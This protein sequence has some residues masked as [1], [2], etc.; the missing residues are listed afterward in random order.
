MRDVLTWFAL[1]GAA[2]SFV[3]YLA[4]RYARQIAGVADALAKVRRSHL[5]VFLA[6]ALV[7]T[8][9]AQ[10]T[11]TNSPPRG[12]SS[13]RV[14]EPGPSVSPED[15]ARGYLLESVTTNAAYSYAMPAN[16]TRYAKWWLR[17]AYED[18]FR[19]DLGDFRFPLGT[20]MCDYLWVYTWGM[21]G[22]RLRDASNRV[23]AT[24]VPMSAVPG[25]SQFWD[26]PT[27]NGTHLLTWQD[28]FLGRDTNTPV[29]AQLELCPTGDYIARSNE[30]ERVYRRVNPDDWDDDGD[31]NDTDTNPY[32]NDGD[33]FGPHQEL[34]QGANEDAYCW[35]DIVVS[36]ANALVTFTGDAPS[37]LP[38]PRFIARAGETNRVIIL[39]GKTYAVTCDMPIAVVDKSDPE[40]EVYQHAAREIY[41]HWPVEIWSEDYGSY[42]EMFVSPDFLDGSFSWSTNGCCEISGS[43]AFYSFLCGG[44]CGCEGCSIDGRYLY[45]G[46]SLTMFSGVCGCEPRG[47]DDDELAGVGV[48]FSRKVLFYE[49]EYYDEALGIT[50]PAW[51]GETV[52]LKCSVSGGQHGGVFCLSLVNMDKLERSGGDML[53][54]GNVSVPANETRSWRAVYTFAEHSDSEGDVQA[55]A[56]FTENLSGEEMSADDTM[57]V[58]MLTASAVEQWPTNMV[59]RVFGVGETASIYKTPNIAATA[60]SARGSCSNAI[61]CIE[62][63][64]PHIEC[65]D[66]VVITAKGCSHDMGFGI[67]A[68]HGYNVIDVNSNIFASAGVSGGFE[69]IFE[70]RLLPQVVSF[71]KLELIEWP[72]V[73]TDPVGYYGQPSKA[74]L[75]DHGLHGAGKWNGVGDENTVGDIARMEINDS[76]WLGGGSFTWPIPNAWR[77]KDHGGEG[78][79]FCNTDQRFELDADGT[80]RLKKFYRAGE[81]TTNGVYRTWETN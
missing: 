73:S 43:G 20:Y 1:V 26:A 62:Y 13:P 74:G 38:D 7:A 18:V 21:A 12:A 23:V 14:I 17:G 45:E 81:R 4:L 28:F 80:T 48:S 24:G 10:K 53:P 22:A 57:T 72:R 56:T 60:V 78:T 49:N 27:T 3:L 71:K 9:C 70:C 35:V 61:L 50:I 67:L 16:G 8:L 39:I 66:Q 58:V 29:S 34:P 42:F 30:V 15:V 41:V 33:S 51:S 32:V 37:A 19:L 69:M 54:I 11:G 44:G 46:Y 79:Y 65:G 63:Y 6:F 64:C 47:D 75:L 59:R 25:L 40:I 2:V 77:I 76:P 68:P 52:A 55:T 31:H 5:A 36:N